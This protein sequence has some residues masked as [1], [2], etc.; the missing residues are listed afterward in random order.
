MPG[1]TVNFFNYSDTVNKRQSRTPRNEVW[2]TT[3]TTTVTVLG[4]GIPIF[5]Q[6]SDEALLT[7]AFDTALTTRTID[8]TFTSNVS[9]VQ[10]PPVSSATLL[11]SG[12]ST[13]T[14]VGL[15]VGIPVA[16]ILALV[17]GFFLWRWRNKQ[18]RSVDESA[19]AY[20]HHQGA[21]EY[22]DTHV[23]PASYGSPLV[24]E[25][26][27]HNQTYRTTHELPG[28]EQR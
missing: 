7:R 21:A 28:G 25:L 1:Q 14:K 10:P 20:E 17:L 23:T 6:K 4:D 26:Q 13:G 8:M 18:H 3:A 15:G 16:V 12:L 11:S 2:T 22:K 19:P 24:H 27:D 5:W 9:P